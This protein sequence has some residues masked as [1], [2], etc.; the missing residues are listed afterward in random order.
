MK[1]L[2]I[3]QP[4]ASLIAEQVKLYEFRRYRAPASVIGDRIAIHAG[5]RAMQVAELDDLLGSRDRLLASCGIRGDDPHMIAVAEGLLHKIR[6]GDVKLPHGAV[7]ATAMLG[8]PLRCTELCRDWLPEAEIDP[9]MWA[10]PLTV[11]KRIQPMDPARGA[12]GFWHW[13]HAGYL[14]HWA[15][16]RSLL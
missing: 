1:A 5:R 12:Q 15:K 13:D 7:I 2:T 16:Q 9:E 14:A 8:E 11:I 6:H 4:W 3:W 10:W